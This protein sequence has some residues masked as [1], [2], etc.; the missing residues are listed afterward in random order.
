[1]LTGSGTS[2][3][4]TTLWTD[5]GTPGLARVAV[6]DADPT[7]SGKE[8]VVGGDSNNIGL[9][10]RSGDDWDGKVIFTDTDK[11]RGVGIGDLDP[12][13]SG[14]EIAV[15]GYSNKV[16]LL[17]RTGIGTGWS[18]QTIF[19]D[20]GRSHDLALGEF[21]PNHIGQEL[22]IGGYS[23][24][25][26]MIIN[27]QLTK[28]PDFNLYGYP[29]TQSAYSG[30]SV[31]FNIGTVSLNGFNDRVE[32]SI[33]NLPSNLK[34]KFYPGTII[35]DAFT[36]LTIT[37]P[38]I[39]DSSDI[40]LTVIATSGEA[41]HNLSLNLQVIG[42]SVQP[43]ID[44]TI[45]EDGAEDIPT[46][47][48]IVIKFTEPIDFDNFAPTMI[49]IVEDESGT[50]FEGEVQYIE[51]SNLMIISDLEAKSG[52]GDG[53]PDS[54]LIKVTL[55]TTIT[56]LSGNALAKQY[57]FSYLTSTEQPPNGHVDIL[58]VYPPADQEAVPTESPIII[59]FSQ[60]MDSSTLTWD[61]I[62]ITS[63]SGE[64]YQGT[65]HYDPDTFTLTIT[66][67]E[68]T[69]GTETG[70]T[71]GAKITVALKSD[72]KT[73]TEEPLTDGYSWDF[74][75]NDPSAEDSDSDTGDENLFLIV[76]ILL[77]IIIFLLL[78]SLASKNKA[79]TEKESEY[80]EKISKLESKGKPGKGT[81]KG[82]KK[83][84]RF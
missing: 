4:A 76:S 58:S 81:I 47:Q 30:S 59:V 25:L 67:L 24:N 80:R 28:E 78:L 69:T 21:D 42:D 15:F 19:V 23:N 38:I 41:T 79:Y 44:S 37:V 83:F 62:E 56:D 7:R 6:G 13:V 34:A 16:T 40:K 51:E 57:Q 35:P 46:K 73:Q 53:L 70:L 55:K 43:E 22:V 3:T 14:N 68:S 50:E 17:T 74:E 64:Q 75:V 27:S 63:D 48:P 18:A 12:T 54:K 29:T 1:M 72:I 36:K 82:S 84:K 20:T 2:W 49:S 31:E 11:I 66:D 45:P 33:A 32:F 10:W 39:K 71:E 65:L 60:P 61:N 52:S 9:I 77:V 26:T 5:P 8:I